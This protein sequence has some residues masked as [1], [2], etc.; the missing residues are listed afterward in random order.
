[1][2]IVNCSLYIVH[3][4]SNIINENNR[5]FGDF[6][7]HCEFFLGTEKKEAEN[8]FSFKF[9]RFQQKKNNTKYKIE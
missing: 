8:L 9:S 2:I 6:L 7:F 5:Y 1:M 3:S 4:M